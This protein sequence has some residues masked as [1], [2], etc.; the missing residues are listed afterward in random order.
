MFFNVF[1]CF[2]MF[3]NVFQCFSMFSM[4]SMF[5]RDSAD[6][7]TGKFLLTGAN[8]TVMFLVPE[9]ILFV[10]WASGVC[11]MFN[12]SNIINKKRI[13]MVFPPRYSAHQTLWHRQVCHRSAWYGEGGGPESWNCWNYR[14]RTI[15]G[16][17]DK[18]KFRT[19][20]SWTFYKKSEESGIEYFVQLRLMNIRQNSKCTRNIRHHIF[21]LR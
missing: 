18:I 15:H 8:Q 3:F 19:I 9:G 14:C 20:R 13:Q 2:S 7:C 4:F 17:L 1:Q 5:E 11:R 21:Q 12:V 6:L 16:W 10:L